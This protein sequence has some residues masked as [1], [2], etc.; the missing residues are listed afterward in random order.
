[1]PLF[2]PYFALALLFFG[3]VI[4]AI[5]AILTTALISPVA[6]GRSAV[7]NLADKDL[8]HIHGAPMGLLALVV[9]VLL[10]TVLILLGFTSFAR[11]VAT[12]ACIALIPFVSQ[13]YP[14]PVGKSFYA[15]LIRQPWL[16]AEMITS[17]SGQSIVGYVLADSG[18]TLTVLMD[19]NRAIYYYPDTTVTKRQICEIGQAGKDAA[20]YR[21]PPGR[22]W[23]VADARVSFGTRLSST[24]WPAIPRPRRDPPG[25]RHPACPLACCRSGDSL[26]AGKIT[27]IRPATVPASV[28]KF[29]L[30]KEKLRLLFRQ[31]PIPLAMHLAAMLGGL[32]AAIAVS[33]IPGIAAWTRPVA[34][35]LWVF[36]AA[37]LVVAVASWPTIKSQ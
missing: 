19:D 1:M 12:I 13:S 20:A 7:G 17:T 24:G 2:L 16:P 37:R 18:T 27:P 8:N 14:L 3:R 34:W 30:P 36:L 32:L 4:L 33:Q 25:S 28:A 35:I 23:T 10:L 15:D 26:M 22:D 21:N 31:L 9:A 6:V 11:A 29:L 5:L